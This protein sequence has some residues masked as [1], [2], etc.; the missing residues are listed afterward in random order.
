MP[1]ISSFR[2]EERLRHAQ[3]GPPEPLR[4]TDFRLLGWFFRPRE[5]VP[6]AVLD[7]EDFDVLED[8]ELFATILFYHNPQKG[9]LKR[10]P[11]RAVL[12]HP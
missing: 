7:L 1:R 4:E 9:D 6:P 11:R 2:S 12:K 5:P 10:V 8:R 3:A